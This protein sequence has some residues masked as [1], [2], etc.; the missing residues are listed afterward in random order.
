MRP[1]LMIP[2]LLLLLPGRAS[3]AEA[4]PT[5]GVDARCAETFD[6]RDEC[7][8]MAPPNPAAV[9]TNAFSLILSQKGVRVT[10]TSGAALL[11][12]AGLAL[13]GIA[14]GGWAVSSAAPVEAAVERQVPDERA[15]FVLT[16]VPALVLAFGGLIL[17]VLAVVAVAGGMLIGTGMDVVGF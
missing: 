15:R 10:A 17:M 1:W 4:A 8:S 13:V 3:G 9:S 2:I 12:V 6:V 14:V 16:K 7:T 5:E 11:G